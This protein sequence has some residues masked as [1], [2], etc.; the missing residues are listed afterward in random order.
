MLA[1]KNKILDSRGGKYQQ[2]ATEVGFQAIVMGSAS[3]GDSGCERR[4]QNAAKLIFFQ[5][6]ALGKKS[7]LICLLVA[8]RFSAVSPLRERVPHPHGMGKGAGNPEF[9]A[10]VW[11]RS[12][13][14]II[15]RWY[16]RIVISSQLPCLLF[17]AL[18]NLRLRQNHS[19]HKCG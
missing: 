19:C 16:W 4:C 8:A 5:L 2:G 14:D 7:S 17:N 10:C 13:Q 15:Y 11:D 18:W 1:Y 6:I 9:I 3:S 12:W